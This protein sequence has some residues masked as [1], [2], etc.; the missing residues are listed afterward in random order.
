M[1]QTEDAL[2]YVKRALAID[3]ED[4]M[5]LYNSACVFAEIGKTEDAMTSLERAVD[6]GFGHMEWIE[7]DPD[8]EVIRG[9]PR[10]KKILETL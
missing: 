10:F 8:L 3:A 4:P 2:R 1:C 9:M 5:L 6:A 7:H